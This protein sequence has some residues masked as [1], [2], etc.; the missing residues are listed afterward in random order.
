MEKN[1]SEQIGQ[2]RPILETHISKSRD[3]RYFLHKTIIVDIKPVSYIEK[4]LNSKQD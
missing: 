1:E 2:N 3:R 4:V